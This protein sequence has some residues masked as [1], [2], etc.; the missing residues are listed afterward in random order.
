MSF[1]RLVSVRMREVVA[2]AS[3]LVRRVLG[4]AATG[5]RRAADGQAPAGGAAGGHAAS[6]SVAALTTGSSLW[7][8]LRSDLYREPRSRSAMFRGLDAVSLAAAVPALLLAIREAGRGS[9]RAELI[10]SGMLSYLAY[11][12]VLYTF[13]LGWT[14]ALPLHATIALAAAVVLTLRLRGM[15]REA[16]TRT[17]PI[18]R[19]QRVS[20]ALLAVLGTG[21]G[22]I[23]GYYLGRRVLTGQPLPEAQLV[24]TPHGALLSAT[25]D[26]VLLV[27]AYLGSAVLLWRGSSWGQPTAGALLTAGL[28]QQVGYQAALVAHSAAGVPGASAFDPAE[29]FIAAVYVAALTLLMGPRRTLTA[30]CVRTELSGIRTGLFA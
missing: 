10:W 5:P 17:L 16:L 4:R 19:Q 3:R 22:A 9:A 12:Y 24:Q 13:G 18:G 14:V 26:L 8:L 27:P 30:R 29:P 7:A 6:L 20:A 28:L 11:T 2:A 15:D 21:L 23:W 1:V 25:A